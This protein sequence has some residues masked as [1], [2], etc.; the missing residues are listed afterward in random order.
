MQK[1][2]LRGGE[3]WGFVVVVFGAGGFVVVVMHTYKATSREKANKC[4]YIPSG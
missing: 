1:L 3:L 2:L 4:L